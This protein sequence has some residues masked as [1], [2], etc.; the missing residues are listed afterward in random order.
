MRL[1]QRG[2][3]GLLDASSS[4][5]LI[6]KIRGG[7]RIEGE[8]EKQAS[9]EERALSG[10]GGRAGRG[11]RQISPQHRCP[12]ASAAARL[13]APVA[14]LE[15]RCRGRGGVGAAQLMP[16]PTPPRGRARRPEWLS[17]RGL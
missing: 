3:E 4:I 5:G 8:A 6:E 9:G 17:R 15:S 11:H 7:S 13:H 2:M 14:P 1:S 16:T 10:P 12:G